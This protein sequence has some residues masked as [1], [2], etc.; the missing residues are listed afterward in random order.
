VVTCPILAGQLV[1]VAAQ[2]LDSGQCVLYCSSSWKCD[3]LRD[4]V[5]VRLSE[6]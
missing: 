2:E 5:D 3:Y 6:S 1:T 4:G